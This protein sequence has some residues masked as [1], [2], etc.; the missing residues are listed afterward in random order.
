MTNRYQT[1]MADIAKMLRSGMRYCFPV[2]H[3]DGTTTFTELNEE[4]FAGSDGFLYL[5]EYTVRAHVKK[6]YQAGYLQGAQDAIDDKWEIERGSEPGLKV[7]PDVN[8]IGAER[9]FIKWESDE[10]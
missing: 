4:A 1:M 2:A 6:A 8:R 7:D 5:I 9:G 10:S 3:P